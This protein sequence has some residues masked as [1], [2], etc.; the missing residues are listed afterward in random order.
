[1]DF[2]L[3]AIGIVF[4]AACGVSVGLTLQNRSR[5]VVAPLKLVFGLLIW[6]VSMVVSVPVVYALGSRD[7]PLSPYGSAVVMLAWWTISSIGWVV[8]GVWYTIRARA[9]ARTPLATD[10]VQTARDS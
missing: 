9:R 8:V 4:L 2:I 5:R 7:G 1:M 6:P 10:D 3:P